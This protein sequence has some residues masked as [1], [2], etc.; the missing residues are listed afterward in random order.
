MWDSERAQGAFGVRG[1]YEDHSGATTTW[2]D[3]EARHTWNA[4]TGKYET[5]RK[6]SAPRTSP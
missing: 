3:F 2:V 1:V 4:R 5:R 6:R